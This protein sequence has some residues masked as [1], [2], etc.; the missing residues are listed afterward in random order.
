MQVFEFVN[1]KELYYAGSHGMD[2]VT[3][4]AS[5]EHTTEKVRAMDYDFTKMYCPFYLKI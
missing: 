5:S 1:L 4:V 3:S 2:M